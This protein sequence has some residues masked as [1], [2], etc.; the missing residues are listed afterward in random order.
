MQLIDIMKDKNLFGS[1]KTDSNGKMVESVFTDKADPHTYIQNFYDKE[2][3]K[4]QDE[5]IDF[6]E[7][8]VMSGGSLLL[9]SEYFSNPNS[10]VG[11]DCTDEY[12]HPTCRDIDGVTYHFNDAYE[13]DFVKKLEKF[14][15]VIDDGQHTLESQVQCLEMYLPKLKKGGVLVIEDIQ[16]INHFDTFIDVSKKISEL[17]TED[18]SYEVECLD[19]RTQGTWCPPDDMMFVVRKS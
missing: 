14:D 8:G 12:L 5:K 2:F 3:S 18:V 13:K 6:L 1:W 9:W 19:F 10:I 15:I 11:V 16:N 17:D 7:I 4:Y